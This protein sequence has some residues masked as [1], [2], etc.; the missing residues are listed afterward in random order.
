MVQGNQIIPFEEKSNS[1][2]NIQKHQTIEIHDVERIY[3]N[4]V[5]RDLVEDN[6]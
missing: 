2:D 6:L 1:F 4:P 5:F 3:N